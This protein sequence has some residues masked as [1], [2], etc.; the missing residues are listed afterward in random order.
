MCFA[1]GHLA[2]AV[3]WV[4]TKMPFWTLLTRVGPG[5]PQATWMV[6]LTACAPG[7]SAKAPQAV[8]LVVDRTGSVKLRNSP[9]L[10]G[11]DSPP[12]NAKVPLGQ[13][14]SSSP[15]PL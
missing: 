14:T 8:E 11:P 3:P 10:F 1:R 5:L 7:F 6:A 13:D 9:L 2:T 12:P 15:L 4:P